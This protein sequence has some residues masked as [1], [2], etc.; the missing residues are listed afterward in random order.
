MNVLKAA[1]FLALG[2]LTAQAFADES[3]DN[4]EAG[5]LPVESYTYGMKLD[6]QKIIT[7]SDIANECA[8]V[9]AQM[10]YEDSHG[11]RHILQYQV[12]GTGCSNG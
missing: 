9:P 6:I 8:P 5:Q 4:A 2:S 10:T 7:V 12:M 11:Q 1:L 3:H